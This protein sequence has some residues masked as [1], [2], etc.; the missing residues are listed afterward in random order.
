MPLGVRI[1]TIRH[2]TARYGDETSGLKMFGP[3]VVVSGV[4]EGQ[5]D[6][7]AGAMSSCFDAGLTDQYV[8]ESAENAP[9]MA[10]AEYSQLTQEEFRNRLL[11]PEFRA[12]ADAAILGD[13]HHGDDVRAVAEW[14]REF[15]QRAD[16]A[17]KSDGSADGAVSG[18]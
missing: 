9:A 17:A 6:E 10:I 3:R 8:V 4:T 16:E 12:A 5:A 18:E 13:T 14:L 11:S 7:I 1:F 15:G 2:D